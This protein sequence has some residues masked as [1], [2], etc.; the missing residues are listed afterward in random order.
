MVTFWLL[1]TL[2]DG[3][4]FLGYFDFAQHKNLKKGLVC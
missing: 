2:T 3:N 1:E 4:S